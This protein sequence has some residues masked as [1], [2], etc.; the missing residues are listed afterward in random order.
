MIFIG[1]FYSNSIVFSIVFLK[2]TIAFFMFSYNVLKSTR[3]LESDLQVRGLDMFLHLR[4]L[5][6]LF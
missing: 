4:S 1:L 3:F 2:R 6:A 5:S